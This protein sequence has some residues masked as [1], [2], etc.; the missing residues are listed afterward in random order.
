L[1]WS[2]QTQKTF[3]RTRNPICL[4]WLKHCSRHPCQARIG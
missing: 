3:S 4:V 1:C 2:T